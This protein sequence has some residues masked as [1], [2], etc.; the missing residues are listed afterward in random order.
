VSNKRLTSD[1]IRKIRN[2]ISIMQKSKEKERHDLN[3]VA[4]EKISNLNMRSSSEVNPARDEFFKAKKDLEILF[5]GKKK[6]LEDEYNKKLNE[7]HENKSNKLN[8]FMNL[9]EVERSKINDDTAEEIN[10]MERKYNDQIAKAQKILDD[11]EREYVKGKSHGK[12]A[13]APIAPAVATEKPAD[14]K[15]P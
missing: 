13:P 12:P 4:D 10:V 7:L 14:R 2:Q 15:V 6:Q 11:D 9:Y 5:K 1:E 3:M 8:V